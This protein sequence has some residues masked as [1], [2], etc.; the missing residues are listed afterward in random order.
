VMVH[1]TDFDDELASQISWIP[2]VRGECV[3][4]ESLGDR[5]EDTEGMVANLG[6]MSRKLS[7]SPSMARR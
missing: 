5:T 4:E 2:M 3:N 1:P 6:T 7:G